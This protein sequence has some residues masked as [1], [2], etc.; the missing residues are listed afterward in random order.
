MPTIKWEP[1][2]DL[3]KYERPKESVQLRSSYQ[4]DFEVPKQQQSSN[5]KPVQAQ[6]T[7]QQTPL[8]KSVAVLMLM[9]QDKRL[10]EK[11][12]ELQRQTFKNL[13]L[14]KNDLDHAISNS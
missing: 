7:A 10:S 2:R 8:C 12:E 11:Y 13:Q 1:K 4:A 6:P 14:R 5:A 9:Q 3:T